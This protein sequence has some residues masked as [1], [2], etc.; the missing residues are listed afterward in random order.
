MAKSKCQ[1][2]GSFALRL[3]TKWKLK[4]KKRRRKNAL[5]LPA[6]RAEHKANWIFTRLTNVHTYYKVGAFNRNSDMAKGF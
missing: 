5:P 1:A 6:S 2:L 4:Q 3:K